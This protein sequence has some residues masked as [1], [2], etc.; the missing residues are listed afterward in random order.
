MEDDP[1]DSLLDLED[2]YYKEGYELGVAD[3]AHAGFVEGK[4][5]GIEK[6][7]EKALEAGK[8]YGK[9][10]IWILRLQNAPEAPEQHLEPVE[11]NFIASELT[12]SAVYNGNHW[13]GTGSPQSDKV[14]ELLETKPKLPT[15]PRLEKHVLT[16]RAL[17]DP[18]HLSLE[19]SDDAVA[20]LDDRLKKALAKAK[21]IERIVGEA[22]EAGDS[23]QSQDS[24][25]KGLQGS[26]SNNIEDL[27]N[28]YVRR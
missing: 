5:F 10:L 19:N 7:Y 11:F 2:E 8:L 1:L 16:L 14:F 18:Q 25:T 17:V 9:A 6:G 22:S 13:Q 23:K 4:L 21:I 3:G 12:S 26:A 28:S 20:D 15:N 24:P 27:R